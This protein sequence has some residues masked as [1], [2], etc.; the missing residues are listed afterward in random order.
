MGNSKQPFYFVLIA[1][2]ANIILDMA[3]VAG[4]HWNA[5]GAA[6]ATVISQA[7]SMFFCIAYMKK[8]NFQFDFRFRSFKIYRDQLAL[9]FKIGLPT[10]MQ[11][12]V[13]SISFLFL[14]AI[15][16]IVGGVSA[17]AAV[18]AVGKFNSFAFMPTM[19]IAASISAM[20]AQN[21]GAGRLDRAVTACRIGTVFSAILTWL[22]FIVVQV[23]P[24]PVLRIFGDDPQMIRNGVVYLRAFSFDFLII[25]FVFC[26]N[27]FL[28]GGGHT[29]FTLI[30]SV[31]SSVLIR[32][33]VCWFLGVTLNWG[34]K[35]VGL[36]AP[37]A[38]FVVLL[39]IIGY[40][41]SGQWK[42]NVIAAHKKQT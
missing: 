40:L 19:A 15:V 35:G 39:T 30:N 3:C 5:F 18:G 10:C 12:S 13:I 42:H 2:A 23:F 33:P 7:L 26:I 1:C 29:L 36:G 16:N 25:P 32:V 38:S 22:F 31:L 37:A 24:A 17:S 41:L 4:L 21:I 34:L 27:G 9:I 8:N 14:T 6:L 28:I 20:S 11:N